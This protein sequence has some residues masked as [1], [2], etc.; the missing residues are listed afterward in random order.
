MK[1]I[2]YESSRKELWDTFVDTSKNGTFLLK[3]DYMEY[4]SDRFEDA[5]V[6]VFEDDGAHLLAIFPASKH[7]LEI[8]SH[9]GL[10]YGGVV[11]GN[12]MTATKMLETFSALKSHYNSLGFKTLL[13]KP[14]P[15]VYHRYPA[16]EDLYALFRNNAE[17]FRC[18]ISTTIFLKDKIRFSEAR[19]RGVKKA[20]KS[21]LAVR[22]THDFETYVNLLGKVL[23]ERHDA[24]P[25]H[26]A[27]ELSLLASRF[28]QNIRLFAAYSG[29]QMLAGVVVYATPLV[30]HAQYI[31]NSED[32]R[33]LGALDMVM[34]HLINTEYSEHRYFDFG[35]STENDGRMLNAGLVAQKEMF[36]GRGITYRSY[37][38]QL[39]D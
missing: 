21:G 29:E 16:D 12:E 18:D 39:S 10:T 22:E 27:Q 15:S 24:K 3:R 38:L 19:R 35:I 2:C 20:T 5:S 31:A 7:G 36:G 13:Y 33:A 6:L 32:G 26:S 34:N 37:R 9:G 8:R 11:C 23:A 17:L 28:P 30:A 25:V 1:I 4:H 14:V